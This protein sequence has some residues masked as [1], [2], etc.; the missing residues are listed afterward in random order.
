MRIAAKLRGVSLLEYEK[1][2]KNR[3]QSA[4]LDGREMV[5]EAARMLVAASANTVM[6]EKP[7][8]KWQLSPFPARWAFFF[9]S[10]W[11]SGF[12]CTLSTRCM[13]IWGQPCRLISVFA[14]AR[15]TS[16]PGC[17]NSRCTSPELRHSLASRSSLIFL[18]PQRP[19]MPPSTDTPLA[20]HFLPCSTC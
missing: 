13:R 7:A 6:V 19:A 11:G 5:V 1:L 10:L 17:C 15:A 9:F 2:D 8:V 18:L 16:T 20:Y 4:L 3:I 12:F 14:R